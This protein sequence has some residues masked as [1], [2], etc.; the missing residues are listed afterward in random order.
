MINKKRQY[1]GLGDG[2]VS[3]RTDR[4]FVLRGEDSEK[5]EIKNEG[6][7]A[8]EEKA[9]ERLNSFLKRGIC[10]WLVTYNE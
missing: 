2:N 9:I 4:I 5:E 10:S 3:T 8:N 7:F 6:P 1:Y